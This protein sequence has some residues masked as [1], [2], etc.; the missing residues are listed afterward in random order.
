MTAGEIAGRAGIFL[1]DT[2]NSRLGK[3][4][5]LRQ[6]NPEY[7]K[8][9]S[10]RPLTPEIDLEPVK[11]NLSRSGLLARANDQLNGKFILF[12][13]S[14]ELP[15]PIDWQADP[16]SGKK[17]D[18][19][20]RLWKGLYGKNN[21]GLRNVWEL[22]RLQGLVDLG[23]A[24][25]LTVD[26]RYARKAR[27][28]IESWASANPY[29]RTVNWASALEVGMRGFSLLFAVSYIG[30]NCKILDNDFKTLLACLFYQHGN[31]L[32][33]HLSS[34]STGFNHA[35]GEAAALASLGSTLTGMPDSDKWL[36]TGK[37]NLEKFIL[38]LIL[39]DGGP[40]E[41]SLHYLAFVCRL[42]VIAGVVSRNNGRTLFSKE[43]LD[44]LAAA[45]RFLC[46]STDR[47]FSISEFGD[48]DDAFLPG[49]AS[50]DI[51]VRYRSTLNLLWL[52]LE[53]EPLAHQFEPDEESLCL[54]GPRA[55][56]EKK[57]SE[58]PQKS[59]LIERFDL[60]GRYVIRTATGNKEKRFKSPEIF[61]R[62]ECGHWGDGKIFAHSHAD[63]LS[64]SL[65]LDGV[66]F[67]ID[68]GTGAYL[69]DKGFR[70]YFRSTL[71]HNTVAV[72]SRSQGEVLDCFLWRRPVHSV[73]DRLEESKGKAV[74]E[75]TH[76]GY[77]K[78]R[79]HESKVVHSRRFTF[80]LQEGRI[81]IEDKFLTRGVHDGWINF[82]LH[83]GCSLEKTADS[84]NPVRIL[85][86]GN[87]LLLQ[88]DPGS[89]VS[90][91]RGEREPLFGW[92]SPGFMR[93]EPCWQVICRVKIEGES[94]FTTAISI[95]E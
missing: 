12:G 56:L 92:F 29:L 69:A 27:E 18:G 50:D 58:S 48:S 67:F 35:A 25:R 16:F 74:I 81:E 43:S 44:R 23:R 80:F 1:A 19:A 63:R 2:W 68:P 9:L 71:A 5:A 73:I 86:G 11:S 26:E 28:L 20:T 17:T 47:G 76:W 72:D 79:G 45:Y 95:P 78:G 30:K 6:A 40:L 14:L 64:F 91:H 38:L 70:E 59:S 36:N 77:T 90:F 75:G 89:L 55:L 87:T 49:P 83:P 42:A 24:Y 46:S 4:K 61:F 53:K 57:V 52:F 39:P 51:K 22:N 41:G 84:E 7:L 94:S 3:D 88:P 33:G 32:A 13:Q 37:R 34:G 8:R 31:Y 10:G 15:W 21:S 85:N 54:F 60:S 93:W 62:F 82:I 65:F 66:P